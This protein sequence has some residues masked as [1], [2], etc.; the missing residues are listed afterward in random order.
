VEA[1]DTVAARHGAP[2]AAVALAW[3]TA[4]PTVAAAVASARTV[5]QL[6]ELLV[7]AALRLDDGD[8]RLLGAASA[9]A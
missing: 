6:Q 1:L 4:Q 7:S 8:L 9:A 2:V 5:E 3:L